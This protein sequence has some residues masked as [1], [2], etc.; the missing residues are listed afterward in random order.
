MKMDENDSKNNPDFKY[1]VIEKG[2]VEATKEKEKEK[3][4]EQ[5]VVFIQDLG[6]T[7]KITIP[8]TESFDIQVCVTQGIVGMCEAVLR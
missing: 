5:E 1:E 4:D 2:E 3:K 8:G 7:V 6:F